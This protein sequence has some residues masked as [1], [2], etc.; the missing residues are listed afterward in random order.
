MQECAR[1]EIDL[2]G[3]HRYCNL[4][5]T[6]LALVSSGGVNLKPLMSRR[7]KLEQAN[8]AFEYFATGEPIKVIICPTEAEAEPLPECQPCE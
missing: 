3:V 7:F 4:Y 8:A 2:V 6:A 1:R 5:P